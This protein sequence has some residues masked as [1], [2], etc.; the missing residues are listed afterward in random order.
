MDRPLLRGTLRIVAGLR[1]G[2]GWLPIAGWFRD[3]APFVHAGDHAI[4]RRFFLGLFRGGGFFCHA[5]VGVE[6]ELRHVGESDGVAAGDALA[7]KLPDEIAE[8]EI[9]FVGGGEAVDVGKKLGGEDFR[10]DKGNFGAVAFG[11][12][13]AER[14]RSGSVAMIG[15]NQHVA[16]L[17]A[18]VL[19]LALIHGKLL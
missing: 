18:S 4:V 10:V 1:D 11:V 9:H 12:E 5:R 17:A 6:K 2:A 3:A 7:G 15:I 16:A 19:E 13:G 8:E 14:R